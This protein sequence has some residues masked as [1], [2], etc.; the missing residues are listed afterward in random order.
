M[1]IDTVCIY[2]C[3]VVWYGDMHIHVSIHI[4]KKQ[5]HIYRCARTYAYTRPTIQQRTNAASSPRTKR[6]TEAQ[7][8]G[9]MRGPSRRWGG[10]PAS[11]PR[12]GD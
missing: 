12:R 1:Y 7:P 4:C 10:F 3:G 5:M 8:K 9:P 2:P 6:K 11:L